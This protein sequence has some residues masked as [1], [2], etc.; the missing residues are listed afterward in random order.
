MITRVCRIGKLHITDIKAIDFLKTISSETSAC[1]AVIVNIAF[2]NIKRVVAAVC[3]VYCF[4]FVDIKIYRCRGNDSCVFI[5]KI[6]EG[7]AAS[8]FEMFKTVS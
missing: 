2:L 3:V 8:Y 4:S 5:I 7:I 1:G 6:T